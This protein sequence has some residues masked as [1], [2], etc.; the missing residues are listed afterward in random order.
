MSDYLEQHEPRSL[1]AREALVDRWFA[2]TGESYDR[3]VAW[4]TMGLDSWWK[5]RLLATLPEKADRV[6][7]LACGTGIVLEKLARKYPGADL[8]GVDL[9]QEYLDIAE[10]KLRERGITAEL[11]HANAESAPLTGS[12]DAV[13]SSYIPKYVD[14]DELLTCITPHV[15][16][17]GIVALHDFTYPKTFVYRR[18]WRAWMW[19]IGNVGRRVF[20]AWEKAFDRELVTVI[21]ETHW[22][23]IYAETFRRHGYVDVESQ[24][25]SARSSM[26]V[27]ARRPP[28][29]A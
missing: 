12:F 21:K 19:V 25:L 9:M 20:P 11:I 5:R 26:I 10:A 29:D 15:R 8:V 13:C 17:G 1:E 2:G 16:P 6:L 28:Q 4:T 24:R 22:P 27:S 23:R 14:P 18:V 3:V 7:D